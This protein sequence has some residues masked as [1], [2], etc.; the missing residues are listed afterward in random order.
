[1]DRF[2][3]AE[4]VSGTID[5]LSAH[6]PRDFLSWTHPHK[7]VR[8]TGLLC[9]LH[10]G[11][12]ESCDDLYLWLADEKARLSLM[13]LKGIGPK[14]VDYLCGLVGLEC[15]AI[16]RHMRVLCA[17]VGIDH[18]GYDELKLAIT[19]AADLMQMPRRQFDG[20]V[21]QIMAQNP[22]MMRE[23]RIVPALGRKENCR[24][25]TVL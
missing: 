25:T 17:W 11:S 10:E 5:V 12:V 15:V 8:F 2:P 4:T 21:W 18:T 1:M 6:G 13:T 9:H 23:D 7:I 19:Y 24:T 3:E 22:E 20:W 16:D 14:T